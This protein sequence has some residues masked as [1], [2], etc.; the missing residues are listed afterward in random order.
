M[1]DKSES[2]VSR[3]QMLTTVTA[4]GSAWAVTAWH[5]PLV[6]STVLPVHAGMTELAIPAL[7]YD[8]ATRE[9]IGDVTISFPDSL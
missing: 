5:K 3:R 4:G 7:G 8:Q 9:Q 1:Q 2:G 6:Q